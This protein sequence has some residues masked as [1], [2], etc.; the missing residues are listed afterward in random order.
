[1]ARKGTPGGIGGAVIGA[2]ILAIA[3]IPKEMWIAIGV[4]GLIALIVWLNSKT[5]KTAESSFTEHNT[6]EPAR[7]EKATRRTTQRHRA[8]EPK[9]RGITPRWVSASETIEVSGTSIAGGMLYFGSGLRAARGDV[10]PA[11]IDPRLPVAREKADPALAQMDYWPS[12]SSI[13]PSARRC[14]VDWL[15]SGR[16]DPRADIGYVF[17]F[18]Y[19]LER[20]ALVDAASDPIAKADLP[21]IEDEVKR[22]IGLYGHSRSFRRYAGSFLDLLASYRAV[23]SIDEA[24]PP[25]VIDSEMPMALRL[26]LGRMAMTGRPVPADW[27][28]AWMRSDPRIPFP[29]A[30]QRCPVESEKMF[31]SL[32]RDRHGEGIKLPAN[33]TKLRM[34]YQPASGGLLGTEFPFATADVPDITAVVAPAKKIE[35]LV[36]E[37]AA[38]LAPYSRYIAKN[39]DQSQSLEAILLLPH[40]LWPAAARSTMQTLNERIGSGLRVMSLGEL[41]SSFGS[42]EELTRDRIRSLAH[43]LEE[44]HIG[45]EPDVLGGARTPKSDDRIILFR[46]ERE[47]GTTRQT[48]VYQAASVTLDLACSVAMADGAPHANELRLLMKQIDGWTQLTE[49]QR[50]RLRARLRMAIDTPPSL[51]SLRSKLDIIPVEG[52]RAIAHLLST[53]AQADGTVDASEVRLLEKVYK[54]LGIDTDFAYSDLH[55]AAATASSAKAP[56]AVEPAAPA[57]G[58]ALDMA[59]IEALQRETAQVSALLSKVFADEGTTSIETL[60][61]REETQPVAD[62]CL[63]GLDAEHSIFLRLLLTRPSWSRQDLADAAADMELMLDGALERIN[64]ASFEQFDEA[65]I[66]GDDPVEISREVLEKIAA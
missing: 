24:H 27:A 50:K 64:E 3:G 1:M 31:V 56:A 54:A 47:D 63:L 49:A 53:L 26:G 37:C 29:K 36:E 51:A 9:G 20:R 60:E 40:A 48:P 23:D 7:L 55:T 65:L 28:H 21:R 35:A 13:S 25:Q 30:L 42:T 66:D 61:E 62:A 38:V 2:I 32:Y 16:T 39:P 22:L 10:D 4:V 52:R 44:I 43:A 18:F 46:T 57:A 19:G 6:D 58:L 33:R 8:Q 15:A 12:Y 45:I 17:L 41:A 59:R 5:N 34:S 11:L 14:Y